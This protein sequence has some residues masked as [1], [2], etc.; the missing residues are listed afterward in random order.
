[1]NTSEE[2]SQIKS[3]IN[4]IESNKDSTFPKEK[5]YQEVKSRCAELRDALENKKELTKQEK[6]NENS[7]HK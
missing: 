6:E 4:Y 7:L 2:I 3:S 1:M 5:E